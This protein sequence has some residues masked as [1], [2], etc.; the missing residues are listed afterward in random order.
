MNLLDDPSLD[1][2]KVR[3]HPLITMTV[4]LTICYFLCSVNSLCDHSATDGCPSRGRSGQTA[5]CAQ[6]SIEEDDRRVH[7]TRR[8]QAFADGTPSLCIPATAV[9]AAATQRQQAAD[10]RRTLAIRGFSKK[11]PSNNDCRAGRGHQGHQRAV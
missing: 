11:V 4:C 8:S 2:I 6:G 7:A 5:A 3:V 1:A 10:V 9:A